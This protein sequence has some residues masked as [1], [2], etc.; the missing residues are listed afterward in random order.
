MKVM[1]KQKMDGK[2]MGPTTLP[3]FFFGARMPDLRIQP[4][5]NACSRGWNTSFCPTLSS[6]SPL[7]FS[8]FPSFPDHAVE[9]APGALR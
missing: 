1:E 4:N 2:V 8:P 5:N 9:I 3:S 6:F 7:F